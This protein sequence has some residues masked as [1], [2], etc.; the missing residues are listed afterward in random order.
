MFLLV[1]FQFEQISLPSA[2]LTP[3]EIIRKRWFFFTDI[4][5]YLSMQ[6]LTHAVDTGFISLASDILLNKCELVF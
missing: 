4:F 6:T 1:R 5:Y 2:V 3:G